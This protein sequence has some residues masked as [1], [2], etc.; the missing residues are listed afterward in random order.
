M[1]VDASA[2]WCEARNTSGLY[3]KA[4]A[5]KIRNMAGVNAAYDIPE[6]PALLLE[7]ENMDADQAAKRIIESV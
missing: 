1:H 7:S 5:G 6:N 4:K 3:A 2:D